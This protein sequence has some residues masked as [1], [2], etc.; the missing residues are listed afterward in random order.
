[1][2]QFEP[3][4]TTGIYKMLATD[5]LK[6]GETKKGKPRHYLGYEKDYPRNPILPPALRQ[7]LLVDTSRVPV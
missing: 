5:N 4:S 7:R 3:S 2:L 6:L 1:M